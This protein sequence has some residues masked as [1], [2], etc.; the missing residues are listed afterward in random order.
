MNTLMSE[1]ETAISYQL[2]VATYAL[3]YNL[4]KNTNNVVQIILILK[5]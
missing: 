2:I 4:V 1:N 3:V 5:L